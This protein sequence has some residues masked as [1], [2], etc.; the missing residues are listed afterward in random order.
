M[1]E[2]EKCVNVV[3]KFG[4]ILSLTRYVPADHR[5]EGAQELPDKVGAADAYRGASFFCGGYAY[6]KWK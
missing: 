1:G 5:G 6:S 4:E 3:A 2:G